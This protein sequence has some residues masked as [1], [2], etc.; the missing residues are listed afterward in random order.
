MSA[1]ASHFDRLL[2]YH[3]WAYRQLLASLASLDETRYRAD[4]GLYFGSIHG[5]LNHLAVVDR[6][7]FSRV[8]HLP[9]PFEKL[10]A[11]AAPTVPPWPQCWPRVSACGAPGWPGRTTTPLAAPLE[12]QNMRG[13]AFRRPH[14][15]I[16][17]H[18]V[19]HGTHHRGQ[20]T[21]AM[22]AMGLESPALD[23][24]YYQPSRP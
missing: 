23:F 11:E 6:I 21:A 22:T 14:G 1:L 24:I 20:V 10:D 7:W 15:E 12:Y 3:G 5:T 17:T 16:L 4:R 8:L 18:L 9:R 19:N 13:D 2:A